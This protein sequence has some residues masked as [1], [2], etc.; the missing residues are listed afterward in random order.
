MRS[1]GR[2]AGAAIGAAA[3]AA[4]VGKLQGRRVEA[5]GVLLYNEVA[6]RGDPTTLTREEVQA[7][8][9]R[10]ALGL[11]CSSCCK[12]RILSMHACGAGVPSGERC[13]QDV[14]TQHVGCMI[15]T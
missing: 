3:S 4:V 13:M 6:G 14:R 10:W 1:A 8:G 5:G 2:L 12:Q 15:R 7:I 9:D 11:A